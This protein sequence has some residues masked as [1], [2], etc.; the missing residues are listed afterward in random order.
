MK[1]A[2]CGSSLTPKTS[3]RKRQLSCCC[4]CGAWLLWLLLLLLVEMLK[5]SECTSGNPASWA[6]W[7]I[8]L[9][10]VLGKELQAPMGRNTCPAGLSS[11]RLQLLVEVA[12]GTEAVLICTAALTAWPSLSTT[13]P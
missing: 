11:E 10:S 2:L 13:K 4:F 8:R 1:Q 9:S 5:F 6:T 3:R 7:F 12:G